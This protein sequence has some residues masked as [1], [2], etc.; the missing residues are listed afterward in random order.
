MKYLDTFIYP[1]EF[2]FHIP[3]I[4]TVVTHPTIQHFK[5]R[6]Q[7]EFTPENRQ[8]RSMLFTY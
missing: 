2:N 3:D 4:M 8:E 7:F 5:E 1:K 6:T